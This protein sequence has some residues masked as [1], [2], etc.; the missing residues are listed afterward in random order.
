MG[1]AA[2]APNVSSEE[3]SELER[4]IRN[5]TTPQQLALRARMIVLST[6]GLKVGQIAR[7]LGVWR[8]T[9]SQWHARWRSSSGSSATVHER[10]SD[11]SRC[12]APARIT[13]EQ[14]CGIIA[15]AC[16][17]PED[18]GLA[19]SHW[20]AQAL[21]DEA[22]KRGIIDRI[23]QRSVGRILKRS[24]PQAA[25]G[26]VLADAQARPGLFSKDGTDLPTLRTGTQRRASRTSHHLHR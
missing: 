7:Q 18:S 26:A 13:P 17:A 11:A 10:L 9:V 2:A 21:A 4:L 12:G 8:K 22:V 1:R 25:P 3:R 5:H 19:L 23:S 24:R 14:V 20:C 15:L 16:E 6:E